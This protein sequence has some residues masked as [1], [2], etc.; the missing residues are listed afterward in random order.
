MNASDRVRV[1][2]GATDST[3]SILYVTA[4][5]I[6][7]SV[8]GSMIVAAFGLNRLVT[9]LVVGAA[10]AVGVV[11]AL[12][13]S[14]SIVLDD[15]AIVVRRFATRRVIDW[16]QVTSIDFAAASAD[17][18]T[19]WTVTLREHGGSELR[20]LALPPVERPFTDA[21]EYDKR[22]QILDIF[23]LARRKS[24]PVVVPLPIAESLQR[25]WKLTVPGY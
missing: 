6:V 4:G 8:F 15:D 17:K 7:G 2:A 14:Q 11:V 1:H 3:R 19:I 21:Y 9:A 18:R 23:T 16:K 5:V 10:I 13:A 12:R 22:Q 24:V 25:H 20:L